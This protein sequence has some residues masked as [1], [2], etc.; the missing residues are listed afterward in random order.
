MHYVQSTT[1]RDYPQG[2][3]KRI[4]PRS[5][6]DFPVPA[7]PVKNK[8][9]RSNIAIL[10]TA[11][12]SADKLYC[13]KRVISPVDPWLLLGLVSEARPLFA[14]EK[15]MDGSIRF[16]LCVLADENA[17]L[18]N[19]GL[20]CAWDELDAPDATLNGCPFIAEG[21]PYDTS[22]LLV[23][24]STLT[25]LEEGLKLFDLGPTFQ[26]LLADDDPETEGWPAVWPLGCW[27]SAKD[28]I[29]GR[30]TD[31]FPNVFPN[32]EEAD[33]IVEL[34]D[35]DMSP[36]SVKSIK[37]SNT[38]WSWAGFG[39]TFGA[40]RVVLVRFAVICDEKISFWSP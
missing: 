36:S 30:D 8:L 31:S 4:L 37:S 39:A 6:I 19:I 12:C 38:A 29:L 5:K 40:A 34:I 27:R 2:A 15:V 14:S 35:A 16:L 32:P 3:C 24:F 17:G 9:L 13:P 18:P 21:L 26:A 28:A 23:L 10:S 25:G 20:D 11:F 22:N 1:S 33:L 7:D